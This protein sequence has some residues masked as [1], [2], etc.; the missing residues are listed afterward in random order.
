V[1]ALSG[2]AKEIFEVGAPMERAFMD[3]GRI[4]LAPDEALLLTAA[5]RFA[6]PERGLLLA[7]R[8]STLVYY[9][10]GSDDTRH[11]ITWQSLRAQ[12]EVSV[13]FGGRTINKK[14]SLVEALADAAL[15][16]NNSLFL[17]KVHLVR[18]ADVEKLR[19]LLLKG[20]WKS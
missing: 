9:A 12:T 18:S 10:A 1:L 11:P 20:P 6:L 13:R 4:E 14:M 16:E 8:M 19:Q 17:R 5:H 7:E 2:H 3:D 15:P